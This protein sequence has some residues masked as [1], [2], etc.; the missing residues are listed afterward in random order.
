[1]ANKEGGVQSQADGA[2]EATRCMGGPPALTPTIRGEL[3]EHVRWLTCEA[4]AMLRKMGG[5]RE[6]FDTSGICQ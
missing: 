1:M 3:P 6:L 2:L 5:E 4:D